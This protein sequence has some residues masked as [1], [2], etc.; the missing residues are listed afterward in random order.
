MPIFKPKPSK[1]IV[2]NAKAAT[3]L[4]SKH[5]S[6]CDSFNDDDE[7]IVN[8]KQERKSIRNKLK[9]GVPISFELDLKDRLRLINNEIKD[10][11]FRRKNYFLDNSPLVFNYFEKKKRIFQV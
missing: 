5:S 3:T 7:S 11:V 1:Q 9:K 2:V 4:D 10:L 6:I 8:L